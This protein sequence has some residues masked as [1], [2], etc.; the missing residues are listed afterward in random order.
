M[1]KLGAFAR[2]AALAPN[3]TATPTATTDFFSSVKAAAAESGGAV[4]LAAATAQVEGRPVVTKEPKVETADKAA[5]DA[6]GGKSSGSSEGKE[7]RRPPSPLPEPWTKKFGPYDSPNLL[8]A[9][10]FK[11]LSS[12]EFKQAEFDANAKFK[13]MSY[14]KA[15]KA[16]H[17]WAQPVK[18]G[19]EAMKNIPGVGKAIGEKIG[20]ILREKAIRYKDITYH[21]AGDMKEPDGSDPTLSK[22]E[23]AKQKKAEREGTA[24]PA[25]TTGK[26]K[27]APK[28]KRANE[29]DDDETG[30][31]P[32]KKSRAGKTSGAGR[33]KKAAVKVEEDS[34]SELEAVETPDEDGE[35]KGGKASKGAKRGG[36]A[37]KKRGG[38][39]GR[40]R[41]KAVVM[42]LDSDEEEGDSAPAPA[43]VKRKKAVIMDLDSDEDEALKVAAKKEV[44]KEDKGAESDG[45]E[46]L[47]DTPKKPPPSKVGVVA[48]A[49]V[50]ASPV[51]AEPK[52]EV[53]VP[54]GGGPAR[55]AQ[56]E[57]GD[58]SDEE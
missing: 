34:E 41:G 32:P 5:G 58:S 35:D 1:S 29:D 47:E 17:A 23:V 40:G 33:G 10:I 2:K 50:K 51:K 20:E 46:V 14:I 42:D 16:I 45:T 24:A 39:A 25:E 15:S 56:I 13:A 12:F 38:A 36:A 6:K 49:D 18:T 44:K 52:K 26:G 57:F 54:L 43:P 53:T 11:Q 48:G 22:A 9:D 4:T 30:S 8:L 37:G 7:E 19:K 27:V 3:T 21:P 31:P 55:R 28:K